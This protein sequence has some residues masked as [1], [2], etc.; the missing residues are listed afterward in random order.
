MT[1]F[2]VLSYIT[3]IV[4]SLHQFPTEF[5]MYFD[6]SDFPNVNFYL[7]SHCLGDLL[8]HITFHLLF[9]LALPPEFSSVFTLHT[10]ISG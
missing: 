7:A 5:T 8:M 2:L 3:T 10:N 4:N 6:L 1:L 9:T